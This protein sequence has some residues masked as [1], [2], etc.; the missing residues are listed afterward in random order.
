MTKPL[1]KSLKRVSD[2][3]E[4]FAFMKAHLNRVQGIPRKKL[5]VVLD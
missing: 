2:I 1:D 4:E 3:E 5:E